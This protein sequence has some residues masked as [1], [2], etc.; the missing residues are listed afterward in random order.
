MSLVSQLLRR[1]GNKSAYWG[2]SSSCPLNFNFPMVRMVSCLSNVSPPLLD[3]LCVWAR[4]LVFELS[5]ITV[6]AYFPSL[7]F[8]QLLL[9]FHSSRASCRRICWRSMA[10]FVSF[11]VRGC[12]GVDVHSAPCNHVTLTLSQEP[13]KTQLSTLAGKGNRK[14][15]E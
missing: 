8:S 7:P 3:M 1:R 6:I 10:I 14:E 11:F 9:F 15:Q 2:R 12:R 13:G 4:P 5:A